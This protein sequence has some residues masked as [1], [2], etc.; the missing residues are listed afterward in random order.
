M[1]HWCNV[2]IVEADNKTVEVVAPLL[3]N[4]NCKVSY[5]KQGL[6]VITHLGKK[7]FDLVLL[8]D[9]LPDEKGFRVLRRIRETEEIKKI[10]VLMMLSS[11]DHKND[12][13]A[14]GA[15]D[16][17]V[18]PFSQQEIKARINPY[19]KNVLSRKKFEEEFQKKDLI[20]KQ[21]D[22][23]FTEME[24]MSRL[25]PLTKILNR[26]AFLE[27]IKDEQVRSRRNQKKFTLVLLNIVKCR[28]YNERQGYECGDYIIKK[29]ADMIHSSLRERD[30]IARWSGD[31]FMILLPE[32]ET[33]GL[34]IIKEKINKKFLD[35]TFEFKG[36][37]H[38][39]D[40]SFSSR[41]CSGNDDLDIILKEIE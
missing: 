15:N 7:G 33:E 3:K 1:S 2:L 30:L 26:R 5:V 9:E 10:P 22:E 32:T 18:K 20:A 19:V 8:T 23:A 16:Y 34:A 28:N 21:L 39:I 29:T 35:K 14:N 13:F 37:S 41:V 11:I 4:Q 12:A 25:D 17:I 6:N 36:M 40:I 24:I 38:R 27:K 31:K